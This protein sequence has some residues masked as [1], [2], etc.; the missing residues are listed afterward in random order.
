LPPKWVD[1]VDQVEEDIRDMDAKMEQLKELHAK[2][3][4]VSFDDSESDK[5][6]EIEA[7]S[8]SITGL[9]RRSEAT[10]RRNVAGGD[11]G[12]DAR[13]RSNIQ[14]SL[15]KK[16]QERSMKLRQLQKTFMSKLHQQK[17]GGNVSELDFLTQET[18]KG[19]RGRQQQTVTIGFNQQQL[20]VV[21]N[22]EDIVNERDEEITRIAKSIEELSQIFKEL[23]VLVIDQGTIL[24]RI[25]FNM[26]QV[27]ERTQEGLVQ[28]NKVSRAA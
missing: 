15:A 23:A 19:S 4:M 28:L 3:L 24:D 2:R 7:L 6:R 25:D 5:E 10:L 12:S 21:D 11:G 20:Q 26:E 18:G 27:V 14:R 22:M 8:H 13:V 9:F 16:L 17:N 1:A